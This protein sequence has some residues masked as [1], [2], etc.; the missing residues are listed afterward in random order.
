VNVGKL[1]I[2]E[3]DGFAPCTPAGVMLLLAEPACRWRAPR[4]W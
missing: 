2:G 4:S 1:L 3:R